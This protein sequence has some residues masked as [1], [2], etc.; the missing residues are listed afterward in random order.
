MP[1][2]YLLPCSCGKKVSVSASQSG[3]MAACEC[4]RQL[5]VPTRGGLLKLEQVPGG[6]SLGSRPPRPTWGP[7]QGLLFLGSVAAVIF[8]SAALYVY[9]NPPK[10][11]V[12][13]FMERA[14]PLEAWGYYLSFRGGIDVSGVPY[15]VDLAKQM[16]SRNVWTTTWLVLAAVGLLAA[17]AS[18][19]IPVEA[20]K[21]PAKRPPATAPTRG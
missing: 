4:G 16:T 2:K 8:L 11:I 15:N 5:E 20:A 12:L 1:T 19:F 17:V 13:D 3:L 18:R 14:N 7:R 21:R 10:D 6:P 9:A